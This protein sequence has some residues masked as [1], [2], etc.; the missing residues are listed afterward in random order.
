MCVLYINFI[1][2]YFIH[3]FNNMYFIHIM[4]NRNNRVVIAL[5][6]STHCKLSSLGSVTDSFDDVVESLIVFYEKYGN[7]KS[8]KTRT[9]TKTTTKQGGSQCT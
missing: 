5:K 2:M 9:A 3:K 8:R 1:N 4:M 7:G 6:S